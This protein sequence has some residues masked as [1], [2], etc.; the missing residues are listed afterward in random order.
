MKACEKVK[1]IL[2]DTVSVS[3][4]ELDA[5]EK[6]SEISESI[7]NSFRSVCAK[8][9][10]DMQRY[11]IRI[12]YNPS[13]YEYFRKASVYLKDSLNPYLWDWAEIKI[14]DVKF[15][16][17]DKYNKTDEQCIKNFKA[18]NIKYV[19]VD[20]DYLNSEEHP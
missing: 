7:Q 6:R 10:I 16:N 5:E 19:E 8:S 18:P 15:K 12:E 4:N 9:G 20:L 3:F 14:V 13:S 17:S 2:P 1:E 11:S